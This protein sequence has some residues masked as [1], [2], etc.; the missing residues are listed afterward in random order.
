MMPRLQGKV[1][2]ITG[3]SSGLGLA[4]AQ[5]F[6]REGAFVYLTGRRQND[7]DMAALAIGRDRMK[8]VVAKLVRK[9]ASPTKCRVTF[10]RTLQAVTEQPG[11]IEDDFTA[12]FPDGARLGLLD[13]SEEEPAQAG[14]LLF[15]EDAY[16]AGVAF[17]VELRTTA[18]YKHGVEI[19][20]SDA[21]RR[22]VKKIFADSAVKLVGIASPERFDSP[23]AAKLAAAIEGAKAHVKLSHDVGAT[24]VRVFPNDFHKEV[25]EEQTI[26]QIAKALNAVGKF[27]ADYGQMVR[28]E[29]H[30]SA[31]RLTT[32]RKI[33]DMIDQKNV[34]VKLNSDAKDAVGNS[35]AQNFALVKDRLGDTLRD[36]LGRHRREP[37]MRL[38]AARTEAVLTE[39]RAR[40]SRKHIHHLDAAVRFF[41]P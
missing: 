32:L 10:A 33:L 13:G 3:G 1:A 40:R 4:T 30:G 16:R 39:V 37:L 26:A 24:G 34:R 12:G 14:C 41:H 36:F 23:D 6:V 28:L 9:L 11:R 31:G 19:D 15:A 5:R 27:A 18:K 38:A 29:N 17:G 7:L 20:I 2:V 21:R 25:P 22:E 35:F 8:E